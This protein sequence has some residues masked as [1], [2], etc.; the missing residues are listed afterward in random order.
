MEDNTKR[1][2]VMSIL[3]Y[4]IGTFIFAAGL[5]TKTAVSIILFYIIASIL[6][7]CGILALYNNYKKN[8]QIKLYLYLIVVGIVFLFLNTAALINNL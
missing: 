7:I 6:I 3:A 4:A 1:L 8:H 2:T 5:M